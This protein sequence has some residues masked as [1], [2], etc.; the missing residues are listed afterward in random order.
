[1][2]R[3]L[4]EAAC[5]R[6]SGSESWPAQR[7]TD[8]MKVNT[9]NIWT[10]DACRG[11]R[12]LLTHARIWPVCAYTCP[13]CICE[14][15]HHAGSQH[16]ESMPLMPNWTRHTE[17]SSSYLGGLRFERLCEHSQSVWGN[18]GHEWVELPDQPDGRGSSTCLLHVGLCACMYVI[19]YVCM[20]LCMY[21]CMYVCIY[22]CMYSRVYVWESTWTVLRA[23]RAT[24]ITDIHLHI[25]THTNRTSRQHK[26]HPYAHVHIRHTSC[27]NQYKSETY[28][29]V[30]VHI[31]AYGHRIQASNH[32]TW[33][34]MT[35][36]CFAHSIT[37]IN[38]HTHT[39]AGTLTWQSSMT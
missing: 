15:V 38:T 2:S 26:S 1:M 12:E 11:M 18:L 30:H 32:C 23:D 37:I 25:Y 3:A 22:V 8:K 6:D 27:P 21:E 28:V 20:Y 36:T 39:H 5:C 17:E 13:L 33:S 24:Q 35:C 19:M 14:C 34:S 10:R 7:W 9:G 31:H 4:A 16:V 29:R